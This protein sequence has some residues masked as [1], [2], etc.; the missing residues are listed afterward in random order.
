[1]RVLHVGKYYPPA[2]GG[3]ET[4]L[5]HMV[6]GLTASGH[7]VRVLVAGRR[8]RT[9]REDLPGAPG[10]LVRA[11]VSGHW[12]SQPLTLTL[13]SLLAGEIASFAPDIVHLHTPNPLGCLAWLLGRPRRGD[14][15]PVLA[16]WH[17]SDIV[18]QR[19]AGRLV[20]PVVARCLEEAAGISV[21]SASLLA[22]SVDLAACRGRVR[23]IPFGI[24]AAP[25]A[26]EPTGD[27]PFLFVGRLVPYKGL[28]TL[29]DAV[30][31]ADR[32]ARSVLAFYRNDDMRPRAIPR[33]PRRRH[34]AR[35]PHRP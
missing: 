4:A 34:A 28:D 29:L 26:A 14:R 17:H 35:S 18:R 3:M 5:R 21:S 10:A 1:M 22:S 25:F 11:G 19:V 9:V 8:R 7:E 27:G 24:D 16:V 2:R 33:P 31:A 13:P 32:E 6:E 23:V 20:Q 30:S 12:N 15:R